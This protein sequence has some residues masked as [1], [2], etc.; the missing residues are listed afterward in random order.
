MAKQ[1]E[2]LSKITFSV[3]LV[4]SIVLLVYSYTLPEA[5]AAGYLTRMSMPKGLLI[6]MIILSAALTLQEWRA[7]Q[8]ALEKNDKPAESESLWPPLIVFVSTLAYAYYFESLGFMITSFLCTIV[9]LRCF[10]IRSWVVTVVYSI[11]VPLSMV[12]VFRHMLG[13]PIP[14]SPFSHLF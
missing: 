10:Q 8:Q 9:T 14:S 3:I 11:L 7:P 13:L 12:L 1:F 5:K 4:L 2:T 6:L